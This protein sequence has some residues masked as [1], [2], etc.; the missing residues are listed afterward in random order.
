MTQEFESRKQRR[1]SESLYKAEGLADSQLAQSPIPGGVANEQRFASVY[2]ASPSVQQTSPPVQAPTI[3]SRRELRMQLAADAEKSTTPDGDQLQVRDQFVADPSITSDRAQGSVS[4]LPANSFPPSSFS[5]TNFPATSFPATSFSAASFR[6]ADVQTAQ[7]PMANTPRASAPVVPESS[8]SRRDLREQLRQPDEPVFLRPASLEPQN[9]DS[10][11]T[12]MF[13]TSSGFSLDTTT[14]SIVLP[15]AP[16]ALSGPLLIEAGVTLRTGSI[17]LPNL[18]TATGSIPL[19][20]AAQIADEA[21]RLDSSTSFVSSIAPVAAQNLIRQNP[22]LGFAPIKNTGSH[23]Q[24]FYG[25]TTS[26]LMLTVGG[27]LVVAWMYRLI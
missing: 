27:L 21:Q 1:V 23:G 14:N 24:L 20:Q 17:P 8:V 5:A 25:L 7:A 22:K 18:N 9:E 3:L 13:Q 16:D 4:S 10:S 6:T 12:Q 26:I 19:P 15:V 11:Q 2:D